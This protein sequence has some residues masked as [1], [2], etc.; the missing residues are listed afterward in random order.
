[1]SFQ[2]KLILTFSW[3]ILNN[4]NLITKKIKWLERN[5]FN[6]YLQFIQSENVSALLRNENY[7][8]NSLVVFHYISK[9][10]V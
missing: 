9:E 8:E 7:I 3:I 10:D 5:P 6:N 2:N 4:L 1:M